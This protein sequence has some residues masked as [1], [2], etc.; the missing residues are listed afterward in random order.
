M[1]LGRQDCLSAL[2]GEPTW[3]GQGRKALWQDLPDFSQLS[4]PSGTLGDQSPLQ[5]PYHGF[6][7][8]E[9]G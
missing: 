8:Q 1:C 3:Q 7:D 6:R 2:P 5:C 9:A 4:L